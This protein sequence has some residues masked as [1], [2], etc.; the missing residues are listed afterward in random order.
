MDNQ[1]VAERFS[2]FREYYDELLSYLTLRLRSRDQAKDVTQ[3][4]FLRVLSQAPSTPIQQPRAFLYRTA[5]N[6]TVDLFRKQQRQPEE[7]LDEA[8]RQ[9]TLVAPAEQY[10]HAEA[11]EQH[12]LLYEA[13]LELP[14]RCREVFILHLFKDRNHAEIAAQLG[15]SNSM[16]EKHI[17]KA[18]LYCRKRCTNLL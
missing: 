16:V 6:L 17:L 11:R 14:P 12:R 4:T 5:L 1:L 8:D 13:V 15:I 2:L 7:S 10:A 9:E 3:E 18:T